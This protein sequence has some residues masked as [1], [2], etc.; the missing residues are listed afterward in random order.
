MRIRLDKK[1]QRKNTRTIY[2]AS[3]DEHY[4]I[5]LPIL[6]LFNQNQKSKT[7]PEIASSVLERGV[8]CLS[9]INMQLVTHFN[10]HNA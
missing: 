5:L 9:N 6:L 10:L 4:D 2:I 8:V 7:I 3:Q 1:S